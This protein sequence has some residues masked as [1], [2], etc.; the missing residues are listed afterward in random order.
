MKNFPKNFDPIF[1]VAVVKLRFQVAVEL[2][3]AKRGMIHTYRIYLLNCGERMLFCGKRTKN[4][5]T[6]GIWKKERGNK[7]QKTIK[8]TL[9]QL[10]Y[11]MIKNTRVCMKC[12]ESLHQEN[13][14]VILWKEE[15]CARGQTLDFRE[16]I[17][18]RMSLEGR[19]LLFK[20]FSL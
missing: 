14:K 9:T 10:L 8:H 2:A 1:G 13:F 15:S 11:V 12:V 16:S 19:L 17:L 18:E 3:T 20:N 6:V 4:T 5:Q 7:L